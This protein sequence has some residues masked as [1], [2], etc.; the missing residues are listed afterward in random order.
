MPKI[1]ICKK[2]CR[3]E[4][5]GLTYCWCITLF[6]DKINGYNS[7]LYE[8]DVEDVEDAEYFLSHTVYNLSFERDITGTFYAAY[9]DDED[10]VA[11]ATIYIQNG[12]VTQVK[13]TPVMP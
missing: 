3:T 1:V 12:K 9:V 5:V 6:T 10:I 7:K 4:P 2:W 11:R 8:E 13:V